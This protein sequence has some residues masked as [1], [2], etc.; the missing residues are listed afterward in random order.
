ML[1]PA[2]TDLQFNLSNSNFL[3]GIDLR[4]LDQE[5]LRQK[6]SMVSQE[7]TL[8]ACSIKENIAYGREASMEEVNY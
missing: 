1:L 5:W 2:F 7:P 6:I 4:E 8:F 3:G